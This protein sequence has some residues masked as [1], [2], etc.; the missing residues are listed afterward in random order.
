[1]FYAGKETRDYSYTIFRG[2]CYFF[3]YSLRKGR[4]KYIKIIILLAKTRWGFV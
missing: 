1:M 2:P 4:S 3:A